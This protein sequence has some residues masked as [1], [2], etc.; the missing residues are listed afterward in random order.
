MMYKA[1]NGMTPIYII[2]PFK[3]TS[4][5]HNR[6]LLSVE[7]DMLCIPRTKTLFTVDGA[8]QWNELP[9]NI[10]HSFKRDD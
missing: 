9:I 1:L 3:K 5:A 2:D 6:L 7:N 4:V 10:K 8:N